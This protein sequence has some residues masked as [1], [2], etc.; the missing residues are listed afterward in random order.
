MNLQSNK[1]TYQSIYSYENMHDP[2]HHTLDD[3]MSL[4]KN[5]SKRYRREDYNEDDYEIV[6]KHSNTGLSEIIL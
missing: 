4:L 3:A 2:N 1:T 5:K 6:C